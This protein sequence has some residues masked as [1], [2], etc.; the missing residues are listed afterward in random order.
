MGAS[1][2]RID[3]LPRKIGSVNSFFFQRVIVFKSLELRQFS[4]FRHETWHIFWKL[5][6]E[7]IGIVVL[8]QDQL[9]ELI[10]SLMSISCL[11]RHRPNQT[12]DRTT[13][14]RTHESVDPPGASLAFVTSSILSTVKSHVPPCTSADEYYI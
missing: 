1:K 14:D 6:D 4:V 9:R 8:A 7:A 12:L 11:D 3:I 5:D 10:N 2:F 13:T